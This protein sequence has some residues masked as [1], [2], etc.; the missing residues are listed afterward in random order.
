MQV[1][2]NQINEEARGQYQLESRR[3]QTSHML[4]WL[5]SCLWYCWSI[6]SIWETQ[7]KKYTKQYGAITSLLCAQQ[8]ENKHRQHIISDDNS[9]CSARSEYFPRSLQSLCWEFAWK[10]TKVR[11]LRQNVCRRPC[12]GLPK[13]PDFSKSHI[14][15]Q[16]GVISSE[17]D[18]KWVQI[19]CDYHQA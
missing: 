16:A 5:Q 4:Y 18:N 10:L 11:I 12:S 19:R 3:R 1:L 17:A 15:D 13:P 2:S 14:Y 6:D 9:R 8:P 7:A